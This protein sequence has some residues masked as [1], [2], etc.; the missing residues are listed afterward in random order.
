MTVRPSH[1]ARRALLSLAVSA[2]SVPAFGQ[3]ALE[4]IIVT[5]Q[6]R[7]ENVQETPLAITALSSVALERKGIQNVRDLM[8][9]APGISG[10]EATGS[11]GAVSVNL[12]GV[13]GGNPATP[14]FD[15]AVGLYLDGVYLG[16]AAGSA[17]DVAELERIEIV[18]GPQGTLYGR[19]A[20][21]GAINYITRQPSGEFRFKG[22]A[23]VGNYDYRGL[24]ASVDL[25]ALGTAGEGLGT[26]ATS[27]AFQIRDRDDIYDNTNPDMP[28]FDNMNREAYRLAA[29]WD[30]S[31]TFSATYAYDYSELDEHV[32]VHNPIGFT[33]LSLASEPFN[34]NG[35]K[36]VSI[37]SSN[38]LQTMQAVAGGLQFL[39][40]TANIQQ[41][42][43]W[44]QDTIA[45]Q[46]NTLAKGNSRPS[47]GSSDTP[48]TSTNETQGHA[49][50]LNWD[51]GELGALGEVNFKSITAQRS[52]ESGASGDIDGVDNRIN[53]GTI[54]D[55]ALIQIGSLLFNPATSGYAN[56]LIDRLRNS[57]AA[58]AFFT[59]S[60]IDFEQFTQ[61]L[62]MNGST[63]RLE[64]NL[65]LYYLEDD[66]EYRNI[67]S[68]LFPLASTAP[69]NFDTSTEALAIYGQG[70]W[71]PPVLDERLAI[72]LGLRYTEETKDVTYLW[73]DAGSGNYISDLS[74]GESLPI[75]PAVYGKKAKEDFHN[76]SGNLTFAYQFTDDLNA[77]VRYATGY[78]SGGYNGDAYDTVNDEANAFQEETI[79]Q[80]EL[81]IKSDWWDK[82]LRVNASV[83]QYDFKDMQVSYLISQGNTAA[84]GII[85][86][87]RADRWG[88]EVE[89]NFAPIED[90]LLGLSYSY[91]NS[92]YKEYADICA[93]GGA[94]VADT[95][96]YAEQGMF[97][98]NQVTMTVDYT[99]ARLPVG[100]VNVHLDGQWQSHTYATAH[101]GGAYD[102]NDPGT[103]KDTP[104]MFE[105]T[106]IDERL[107]FNG[108]L[109]L[110][111]IKVGD[112]EFR[113]ALWGRNLFDQDYRNYGTNYGDT[114]GTVVMMYGEPRTY[115]L[116]ISY[117]Y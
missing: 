90:L 72:T 86:A 39:P 4:E 97:P 114:L 32:T 107:V 43:S 88:A 47:R 12:R 60:M 103:V 62:Q 37:R 99:I 57:Y 93:P 77:F 70:T 67:A 91:L 59:E 2:L 110:D 58:S 8:N 31:D 18:R 84:S 50:T 16:K 69:K 42:G 36:G 87:G 23:S 106:V 104:V 40:Q 78:R 22:T 17:L 68:A 102:T 56:M 27:L 71:T 63:D 92:K 53:G 113:V 1:C 52:I 100:V 3:A 75:V 14:S 108:R 85:N 30:V 65:G 34:P 28:G 38:R 29:K 66:S 116:D 13:S 55:L 109:S 74:G 19:N 117:E 101:S 6:K 54:N 45:F 89:I 25:P 81:G 33:P 20:T 10:F 48:L 21:G 41:L 73:R 105:P 76:V 112:G 61:E 9:T 79:E 95:Q 49:L 64:Y 82:R 83:F 98:S 111:E 26:L 7:Q 80:I 94:C 35:L 51:A 46:Q 11:K 44:L 24:K 96:D 15:P 115:G 5:A